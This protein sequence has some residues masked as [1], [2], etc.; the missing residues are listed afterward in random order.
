[1]AAAELS[2][3]TLLSPPVVLVAVA[4]ELAVLVTLVLVD[5]AVPVV[6]VPVVP[7]VPVVLVPVVL[8][9]VVVAFVVLVLSEPSPESSLQPKAS[10]SSNA[11]YKNEGLSWTKRM[12]EAYGGGAVFQSKRSRRPDPTV[13]MA[14]VPP[15][16]SGVRAA[17]PGEHRARVAW[18]PP[19]T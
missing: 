9:P 3:G 19:S 16:H 15:R 1:M 11:A 13:I 17:A 4:V 6:L 5:V 2:A 7:V 12:A 14:S 8:V 18:R 10:P